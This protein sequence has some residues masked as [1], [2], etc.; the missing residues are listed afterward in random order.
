MGE[1]INLYKDEELII[2]PAF[3]RLFRWEIS[4]KTRFIES[5]LLG[6]PVPP[7]FVFQTE[8]GVWELIDGLQRLSTVFEF[9]GILRDEE[10]D[11]VEPSVLEGTTFLPH[12]RDKRWEDSSKKAK[13]GIGKGQQIEIKRSRIRVEILKKESDPQAKYELFQRL[14]TGGSNLSEQEIRNCVAIMINPEFYKWL[15]DCADYEP[16]VDTT[17]QTETAVKKQANVELA[18]RFFAYRNVKYEKNL[19]VHEYLDAALIR[20]A[21]DKNFPG[22]KE[23][24]VFERTFD[25]ISDALGDDAFKKWDGSKFSGM[26]LQSTY[27]I[28]ATGVSKNLK[29]IEQ[30]PEAKRRSFLAKRAKELWSNEVFKKNSG[31]GVRGSTRLANLLP[32]A[33]EYFAP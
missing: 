17:D 26:F 10:G 18:L 7:I 23:R 19:D 13:D 33:E 32:I 27:E 12:L 25:I 28:M 31:A 6:I 11:V 14:N 4:Q 30:M 29:T 16:F 1:I 3:Q 15:D 2:N 24:D 21:T 9:V 20:M 22:Q 8:E 5:L